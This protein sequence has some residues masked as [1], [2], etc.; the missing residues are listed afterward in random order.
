[1]TP[2]SI[3][4]H[5]PDLL[6]DQEVYEGVMQLDLLLAHLKAGEDNVQALAKDFPVDPAIIEEMVVESFS[7]PSEKELEVLVAS[8]AWFMFKRPVDPKS[9]RQ[10]IATWKQVVRTRLTKA[11]LIFPT[12]ARWLS[13]ATAGIGLIPTL[14]L[15]ATTCTPT[16]QPTH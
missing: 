10:P 8:G 5:R 12:P 16:P 7:S 13:I 3:F 1:M 11:Q 2:Q 4:T 14:D 15:S 9:V 6:H